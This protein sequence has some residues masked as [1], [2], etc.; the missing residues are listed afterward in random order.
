LILA[1]REYADLREIARS[2]KDNY[3]IEVLTQKLKETDRDY[4]AI[5]Q[6]VGFMISGKLVRMRN[7]NDE[8]FE[9]KEYISQKAEVVL[10]RVFDNNQIMLVNSDKLLSA[11]IKHLTPHEF[12][13]NYR[14]LEPKEE[15]FWR[16]Q[17]L[18]DNYIFTIKYSVII[19]SGKKESVIQQI[20]PTR[21]GFN[22]SY[23]MLK[24]YHIT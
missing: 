17:L 6:E 20:L 12:N 22:S 19:V 3:Q 16:K 10:R 23:Q 7:N 14:I 15:I 9:V 4:K 18:G 11:K 5:S 13:D 21:L 8:L 24:E 1:L 2:M